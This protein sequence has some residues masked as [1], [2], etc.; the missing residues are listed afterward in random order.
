MVSGFGL[1]GVCPG[2]FDD[3]LP[4]V[5]L[6]GLVDDVLF[7]GK[8]RCRF[9]LGPGFCTAGNMLLCAADVAAGCVA[10]EFSLPGA[11]GVAVCAFAAPASSA[12]ITS[13]EVE[14]F[15]MSSVLCP[16]I[17]THWAARCSRLACAP[18]A[19]DFR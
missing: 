2:L 15:V 11:G 5:L 13:A 16:L 8:G 12:A 18:P 10:C 6:L 3:M 9:G 4:D 19:R 17:K 14:S 1:S 7:V